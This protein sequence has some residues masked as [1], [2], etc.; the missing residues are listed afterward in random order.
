MEVQKK[1]VS[2]F[3]TKRHHKLGGFIS[4]F[5]LSLCL[6][7]SYFY[8]SK[9]LE[10][11]HLLAANADLVFKKKQFWR[12]ITSL[13][14]HADLKHLLS[15]SM[16]LGFLCY[17][18]ASF[19]NKLTL[20]F[21]FIFGGAITN[22]LCLLF[23]PAH[24]YLVGASGVIF[25]LWGFWLV[26]FMGIETRYGLISR[27]IRAVGVFLI[28]LVPTSYSPQ[29]SYLA[30]Y[31]GFFIGMLGGIM[32]YFIFKDRILAYE[33]WSF[34]FSFDDELDPKLWEES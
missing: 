20:S 24:V 25:L 15:N 3:L 13:F 31:M 4:F 12:L 16:M 17:F 2:N 21:L 27:T 10:M 28:L 18:V 33:Q 26:L 1:F 23:Y 11:S 22:A 6:L 32:Y 29:T 34:K 9:N 19:Y 7:I 14:V 30:H 5:F 8:W